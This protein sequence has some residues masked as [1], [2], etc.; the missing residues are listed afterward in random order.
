[1]TQ[2]RRDVL[3]GLTTALTGR[4]T[5]RNNRNRVDRRSVFNALLCEGGVMLLWQDVNDPDTVIIGE[6]AEWKSKELGKMKRYVG[7]SSI[8]I[9]GVNDLFGGDAVEA[10]KR[11]KHQ[12]AG[13][14]VEVQFVVLTVDDEDVSGCRESLG[15]LQAEYSAA[16]ND[17]PV[18]AKEIMAVIQWYENIGVEA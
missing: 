7:W 18:S 5:A 9:D 17:Q 3:I 6:K 10:V 2:K 14:A 1:M 11:L 12:P 8:H 15:K 13:T 4:R 16:L